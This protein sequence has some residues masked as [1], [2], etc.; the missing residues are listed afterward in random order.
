M[1]ASHRTTQIRIFESWTISA[2]RCQLPHSAHVSS[3]VKSSVNTK[4]GSTM[5]GGKA[6]EARLRG[7]ALGLFILALSACASRG[8]SE[9]DPADFSS[10]WVDITSGGVFGDFKTTA[11]KPE[12]VIT[13]R[14]K[15][16]QPVWVK[17]RFAVP[18]TN[19]E[20]ELTKKLAPGK[21]AQYLCRQE[22]LAADTDYPIFVSVYM[23]DGLTNKAET[24]QTKMRFEKGDVAAL[25][26]F[27][28]PPTLPATYNDI[29]YS[30]KLNVATA[31][32]GNLAFD[33]GT[34]VVSKDDVKYSSESKTVVI[35]VSQ[36]RSVEFVALGTPTSSNNWVAVKYVLAATTRVI[37]F[38]CCNFF[39]GDSRAFLQDAERAI[40]YVFET[41][42]TDK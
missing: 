24:A 29:N 2:F 12:I 11:G 1:P 6:L 4:G 13:I 42:E 9:F 5:P 21:G 41:Q 19:Q 14:N 36:I 22:T 8:L 40:R 30:E 37:G 17:V 28:T 33:K 35:P 39:S 3:S 32:F 16:E 7:V 25:A 26:K 34:L 27:L 10:K 38:S 31:M 15:S 18:S 23:N 20:C